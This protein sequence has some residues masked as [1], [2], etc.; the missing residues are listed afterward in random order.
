M[1]LASFLN[2]FCL[3]GWPLC[4]IGPASFVMPSASFALPPAMALLMP[5]L[6]TSFF[7]HGLGDGRPLVNDEG[8]SC[9]NTEVLQV[10]GK[11]NTI[12]SL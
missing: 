12:P 4:P 1:V 11:V 9:E 2:A 5:V 8:G 7:L 6:S 10:H 3:K